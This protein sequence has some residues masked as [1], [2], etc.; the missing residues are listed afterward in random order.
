MGFFARVCA[1]ETL[2]P[3]PV[4]DLTGN[5]TE[6]G[7]G[8][9]G[10]LNFSP[11]PQRPITHYDVVT[12]M[13]RVTEMEEIR[14]IV[15]EVDQA[16][17]SLAQ[18]QEIKRAM[19]LVKDAGKEVWLYSDILSFKTALLG[20]AAS[21]FIVNPEGSVS[22]S[23]LYSENMYFKGLLDKVGV[24]VDVVHVGDFK[25]AGE[26]YYRAGP[27]EASLKQSEILLDSLYVSLLTEIAVGRG[28][29]RDSLQSFIDEGVATV[30]VAEELGLVDR[31][32][33][34]TDLVL[35]LQKVYGEEQ[36][37]DRNYVRNGEKQ[38]EI[39][40][41]FDLMKLLFS[42]GKNSKPTEDYVA[43]VVFEGGIDLV[44]I[45][46]VRE[47][48]LRLMDEEKCRALVLRISSPGGSALASEILWEAIDEFS[49]T[50]RPVVV[51]MGAVAASGGYYI[52]S[53]ADVI[54]ADPMSITGSIGVVGMKVALGEMMEKVGIT[55]HAIQ[56]GKHADLY[57][58]T[59]PFSR[60]ERKIVRESM[61]DVY[62]TFKKRIIEGR[63]ERLV[64]DLE[65]L[66][67]GRVYSG[68]DALRVGL[69]DEMGGL[70]D[71][72]AK[73]AELADLE[74]VQSLMFPEPKS[75]FDSLFETQGDAGSDHFLSLQ[76]VRKPFSWLP[77]LIQ[78][79]GILAFLPEEKRR[80]VVAGLHQL[81]ILEEDRIQLLAPP[82]PR[83]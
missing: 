23:G 70:N 37:F 72:I 18:L 28:V 30:E 39:G 24:E 25:S 3:I 56:K 63:G 66:A 33:C 8:E 19:A 44:S 79:E 54:F 20:S 68:R 76:S 12:S 61:L 46:P 1:S 35:E 21:Q 82:L 42:S 74:D 5:I 49:Q 32:Q 59:R 14:A 50:E 65:K 60:N 34:R 51:S 29:T 16:N 31:L 2:V 67:R 15:V 80:E 4:Y 40:G 45:D 53:G 22:M 10:L 13:Q 52:A 77:E 47:E 69:V 48:I 71:A 81:R 36:V 38:P 11:N 64:G 17:F 7:M 78:E 62:G 6:S 41:F 75:A 27:S 55:T 73:A 9:V 58:S 83:F 57:N 26:N 43:V